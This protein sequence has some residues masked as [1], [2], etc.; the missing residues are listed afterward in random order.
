M[1]EWTDIA[2]SLG[3]RT[4][5]ETDVIL[6]IF[7][8]SRG[9]TRA[10]VYGG[11]SQKKRPLI[12]A[13]NT[14]EVQWKAKSEAALGHFSVA[15]ATNQR[16][17]RFMTDPLALAGLSAVTSIMR[18]G[19]PEG[20]AKQGLFEATETL[21]DVMGEP[22]VWPAIFIKWEIGFL[23][24]MGYGLDLET[25]ALSGGNDGLTHV[26]PKTGR[27]V[28]GSEA[29][30]YLDKLL[31]LPA[32]LTDSK[33]PPSPYDIGAGFRLTGHFLVH[34]LFA[35]LN[36]D[37]PEAR[38]LMLERLEK[39]ERLIMPK[40]PDTGTAPMQ[41]HSGERPTYMGAKPDVPEHKRVSRKVRQP[42]N[43]K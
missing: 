18:D 26:S 12:E 38:Y 20:E 16:A 43:R 29:E 36:R 33:A 31:P 42:M 10:M 37:A 15:D 2:I 6:D 24:Q 22:D 17:A 32:F 30:Q 8:P 19:L 5:G 27:A 40:R 4:F 11:I 35:D 28:R 39:A 9:H 14:I 41:Q 25:C 34:R 21:L 23:Q 7:T 1:A 3:A 13:G